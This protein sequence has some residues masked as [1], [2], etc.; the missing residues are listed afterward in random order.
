[1]AK[2]PESPTEP[3]GESAQDVAIDE[4]SAS[5]MVTDPPVDVEVAKDESPSAE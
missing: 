2:S 3:A 1:V 5:E 4:A